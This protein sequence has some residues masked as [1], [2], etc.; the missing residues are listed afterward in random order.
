[1]WQVKCKTL[2]CNKAWDKTKVS[3]SHTNVKN[4][5]RYQLFFCFILIITTARR[6]S[7]PEQRYIVSKASSVTTNTVLQTDTSQSNSSYL[8][9]VKYLRIRNVIKN[10][11]Y[12]VLVSFNRT[13]LV[14]I[15]T[16]TNYFVPLTSKKRSVGF[17]VLYQ[18]IIRT[19]VW[20]YETSNWNW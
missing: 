18:R 5:A 4:I 15:G 11:V 10:C 19:C 2:V 9:I 14:N 6:E 13:S 16:S 3:S 1:M 7:L 17:P 12:Q 20:S 8:C